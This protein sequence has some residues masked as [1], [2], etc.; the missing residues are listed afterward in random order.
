[1]PLITAPNRYYF[2]LFFQNRHSAMLKGRVVR[3]DQSDNHIYK[4]FLFYLRPEIIFAQQPPSPLTPPT[5]ILH[6]SYA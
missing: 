4:C 6:H 1:M 3:R 5:I 2:I